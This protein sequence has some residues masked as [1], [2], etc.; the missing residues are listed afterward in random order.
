[1]EADS[2][3]KY[4]QYRYLP[5]N[6][7]GELSNPELRILPSPVDHILRLFEYEKKSLSPGYP[8]W[9]VTGLGVLKSSNQP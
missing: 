8:D 7:N 1:M 2:K 3:H 5:G 6:G 9:E 4:N